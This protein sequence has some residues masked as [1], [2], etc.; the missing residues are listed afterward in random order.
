[1]KKRILF[2]HFDLKGGGAEKVLVNLVNNLDKDKFDITVKTIFGIGHHI[3]NLAPHIKYQYIFKRQFPGFTYLQKLFSPRFLHRLFIKEK[4]DIEIAYLETSPTRIISGC[5][6]VD[7]KKMAWLHITIDKFPWFRNQREM[8]KAYHKFDKVVSVSHDVQNAFIK[9]SGLSDLPFVV[10]RNVVDSDYIKEQAKEEIGITLDH[11]KTNI[12]YIGRLIPAK[13][14]M[15]LLR[16]LTEI[17]SCGIDNWHLYFI[18]T[19]ELKQEIRDYVS[20]NGLEHD[21][22]LLGYQTNPYKFVARM[23]LY[24]C[25]SHAEGYSTAATEALIL[26]I[27]V[28]TTDCGGMK[29]IL[30]NGKYGLIVPDDDLEFE[31]G[32]REMLSDSNLLQQYKQ[33]AI[34]RCHFFEKETIVREYENLIL[35]L[36]Q[37]QEC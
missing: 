19:G 24:V 3:E 35:S 22:T 32:L 10:Q 5:P 27:P 9:S 29:E 4:Y 17:K 7:T 30:D 23:D 20:A 8:S 13:D 18:G 14:P 1:M 33:L 6:H 15:R 28:F 37:S 2:L 16:A 36:I 34:E 12:C 21:V 26:H 25:S 11:S 31:N